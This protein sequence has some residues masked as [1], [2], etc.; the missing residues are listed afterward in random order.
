MQPADA[1]PLE[2]LLVALPET[3]GS[4]LYGML[5]VLGAAGT[6]W[7]QLTGEAPGRPL[8]RPRI[9]GPTRAP[10]RC[11]NGVPVCPE[12]G[13]EDDPEAPLV[14]VPELWLAPDDDL[15]GRHP[16]LLDW[17]RRRY[18]SGSHLYSA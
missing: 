17:L 7:A 2:V 4:A 14:V 6:L 16:E 12:L 11:G 13:L 5:D 8:L 15:R 18:R 3:A 1:P 10:F 9:L